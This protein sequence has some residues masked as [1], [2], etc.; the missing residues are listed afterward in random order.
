MKRYCIAFIMLFACVAAKAETVQVKDSIQIAKIW[1]AGAHNAFTDLIRFKN[2]FYCSFREGAGHSGGNGKNGKV[3]ILTSKNGKKWESI[4]LLET[5]GVDLRDPKLSVTPDNRMMVIMAGVTFDKT[6]F[7]EQLYPMVSF[8]NQSG[9]AFSLPTKSIVDPAISPSRDWIWRVA[10][11]KGIGYGINYQLKENARDR[12]SL[13]RDAWLVYLMRTTD[14]KHFEKVSQLD[15]PDLPNEATVRFDDN[16]NAYVL[17]RKEA[18][19]KMGVLAKSGFPY[20][21]WEYHDIDFRLGGPNFIFFGNNKLI[22]GT[23]LYEAVTSTG[24]LLTDL[25]GRV[26]KTIKLKGSGDT[27]YPGMLIYKKKLWVSYYSSHEA[28]T[29]IYMAQIPMSELETL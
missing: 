23:R 28:K 6:N 22:V 26:L 20:N 13:K 19:D 25:N 18:G 24:I 14:G 27:S 3:R 5:E 1:D 8:S 21:N 17:V 15:I 11:H 7:L 29:S 9:K 2:R 16:D 10:W 12:S 4:A